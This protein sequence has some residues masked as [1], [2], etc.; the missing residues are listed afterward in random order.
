MWSGGSSV[1]VSQLGDYFDELTPM[2]LT[3]DTR[4]TNHGYRNGRPTSRQAVLRA[5]TAVLVDS[6]G[7]PR[8]RCACGN[9]L[10]APRPVQVAPVYTGA[11]WTDFDP[12][13]II[14]VNQTTVV[15]ETFV[16]V[17][18]TTGDE[19]TR[20]A[21]DDGSSDAPVEASIWQIDLSATKAE[22]DSFNTTSIDWSGQ[23]TIADDGTVSGTAQGTWTFDGDCYA[24]SGE[25]QSTSSSRGTLTVTLTGQVVT[26]ELGRFV[27]IEPT[28][29]DFVIDSYVGNPP[30]AVC[31]QDIYDNVESWVAPSFTTVE[32]QAEGDA[33]TA[34]Y[35]SGG[36]TG[37]VTLTPIG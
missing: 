15:I 1:T 23:L 19:F 4:V 29:G 22:T 12:D 2:I 17:D 6:Y 35:E 28:Y 34:A 36:F 33:V 26:T 9:P 37:E 31:E 10:T 25:V 20:P 8:S 32:L 11:R 5:G 18:V 30:G 14:V 7:V 3:S 27:S 21:G 13:T 16:L 24:S